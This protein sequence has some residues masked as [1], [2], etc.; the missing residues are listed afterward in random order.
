MKVIYPKYVYSLHLIKRLHKF[1]WPKP[2][3]NG[4]V[5]KLKD[6]MRE[7]GADH[8]I[9]VTEA[10]PKDMPTFRLRGGVWVCT[11]EEIFSRFSIFI[12]NTNCT[13]RMA[14]ATEIRN[15]VIDQLMTIKDA[16]YLQA[17]SDMIRTSHVQEETV[18]LTEEQ[19]IMLAMSE[20]DVEAGRTIEQQML[21]ERE[22][23][24]L[25]GK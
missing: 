12:G 25:K 21:H 4:R 20:E 7:H 3:Q 15:R 14:T 9:I 24:W 2:D 6:D 11:Y 13:E 17:L 8:G 22:L 1:L 16:G 5:A 10:M 23:R 19:K 18:G